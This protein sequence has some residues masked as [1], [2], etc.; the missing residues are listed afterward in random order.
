M[1]FICIHDAIGGFI[2]LGKTKG[3]SG[4]CPVCVDETASVYL[5]SSRKLVYMRHRWF[6]L[7]KHK[8]CNMKSHFDN[9]VEKDSALK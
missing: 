3:K 8:Y 1:I 5:A 9:T 7:I 4:A 6:L 2:V